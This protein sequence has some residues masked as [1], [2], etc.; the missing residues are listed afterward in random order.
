MADRADDPTQDAPSDPAP[1][2]TDAAVD[3]GNYGVLRRRL[4]D[5]ASAVK[6]A[7]DTLNA[8]RVDRFGSVSFEVLGQERVRTEHA[9]TPHDMVPIGDHLLVG[10]EV[11]L[12]LKQTTSPGDVFGLYTIDRSGDVPT[13]RPAA[14]SAR[15]F[16]EGPAFDRE[17]NELF[18]Y[19]ADARLT[20]LRRVDGR[21]LAVFRIGKRPE[22]VKV[23]RWDLTAD[24]TPTYVDNRGERDHVFP[25]AHD[26]TWTATTRDDHVRGRHPHVNVLDTVFVETVG[27]DLTVKVED[28]TETGEGVYSEPVDDPNQSLD[29][30]AIAYA[31]RGSLLLLRIT[32]FNE[33]VTR[34]LVFV[35]TTRQVLRI[36]ALGASCVTLPEDH[37][38]LFPGGYVLRDGQHKVFD[39]EHDGMRFVRRLDAPNGEDVLY[40]FHRASDGLY[41]LYSYNLIRKDVRTPIHAHGWSL[42][43]DGTL[44]VFRAQPDPTRVH[45]IQLWR[46]P[47]V[48]PEH[49]DPAAHGDDLIARVGNA[50]LV[51]GVSDALTLARLATHPEPTRA[52]FDELAAGCQR[53]LDAHYWASDASMHGL[54]EA[55]EA[56][57]QATEQVVDEFEKVLVLQRRA[58]DTLRAAREEHA[59]LMDAVRTERLTSIDA[60]LGAMT[61]LR[62]HRGHLITL[63]DVRFADR[64]AL[65]ALGDEAETR[66]E[67]VGQATIRFL[68]GE[69]AFAPLIQ[70]LA[71]VEA[72]L[73]G[74]RR[75][76][77]LEPWAERLTQTAEGVDLL[78]EVVAGLEVDDP[79][80][81]AALLDR[82][83]EVFSTANRVRLALEQREEALAAKEGEAE[84]SAQIKLLS[85]AVQ[86]ALARCDTPEA[87]DEQLS[88]LLLQVEELEARFGASDAFLPALTTQ[89]EDVHSAFAARRQRLLDDRNRR[90]AARVAAAD[91]IL[92]GLARRARTHT[93]EDALNS[94]FAADPMVGRLRALADEL[95]SL[96]DT[97][98][99]ED[100]RGRLRRTR[101]DALR[102][103]RDDAE[104]FDAD[105]LIS[106][107]RHKFTVNTQP[108][109]LALVPDGEGDDLHVALTLTGTQFR[110]RL[111]DPDVLAARAYWDQALVSETEAVYRAEYLA[112]RVLDAAQRGDGLDVSTLEQAL[113]TEAGL[114]D[115]VRSHTAEAWDEGY[116]RGVHDVDAAAIL[117]ALVQLRQAAGWQRFGTR[118][119]ALAMLFRG[120]HTDAPW[121]AWQAR[122]RTLVRIRD[123]LGPGGAAEAFATELTGVL[124]A[125]LQEIGFDVPGGPSQWAS[126]LPAAGAALVDALATEP[127]RMAVS[128]AAQDLRARLDRWIEDHGGRGAFDDRLRA[129]SDRPVEHLQV[130]HAWC[131]AIASTADAPADPG[132]AFETA[133]WWLVERQVDIQ[134]EA[135]EARTTVQ[136]LLGRHPRVRDGAMDL[137]LAP[138]LDRLTRF[139]TERVPGFRAWRATRHDVLE[140]WR[141][142]LRIDE[143]EPKVMSAF[144]RN[145][146]IQDAYLPLIGDN[147]A[148]QIGAAGDAKRTDLMGLLLLV[149]PP[150][151]GKTT[152]MEYVADRLGLVFVKVNGPALGHGVTSL[153]PEEAPNAT[154]RQEVDKINLALELGDNVLLYLDDI[155]HTNPELLQKFISLCDASRRI[156]GVWNGR[157][158]TYDL[159]GRK[160]AV[161]MAG[162]PYTESGDR[163]QVPDM[164]ANRAD[165]YNLGDVLDGREDVFA[166]SFV[167]NALTS[168]PVLQPLADRAQADVYA[169]VRM[170]QGEEL[171]P[172]ALSHDYSAVERS[173]ILTVLRHL[174]RCRDVLLRVN[175]EYVRSAAME[176]RF[177]TEPRFQLQGSYRNMAKLAQRIVPALRDEEVDRLIDDHYRGESQTLT[178]GAEFNL[179]RLAELRGR[180]DEVGAERLDAIRQETRRQRL[181]GG[182]GDDPA[183]RVVGVLSGL[184]EAVGTL[185][186]GLRDPAVPH[187]LAG[188]HEQLS[189]LRETMAS[190]RGTTQHLADLARALRAVHGQLAEAPPPDLQAVAGPL[191]AIAT[192]LATATPAPAPAVPG[193]MQDML[194]ELRSL[195]DAVR[196]SQGDPGALDHDARRARLLDQARRA[197]GGDLRRVPSDGDP[198]L[199][200]A[201]SVIEMLTVHML[202][203]ARAHLPKDAHEAWTQDLRRT[204]ASAIADLAARADRAREE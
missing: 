76:L 84:F 9:N 63:Q 100:L 165:T 157:T 52:A 115:I 36:D 26:F 33:A 114:L 123:T 90:V 112:W 147:F 155:Q 50:E 66:F 15:S 107:G 3:Q 127:A 93:D 151:Y 186:P 31:D 124:R 176:D 103:L 46:T 116:D 8:Q 68:E 77:E 138:F 75:T 146:L 73:P 59:S 14:E 128:S 173:E 188:L 160:F 196:P 74:V 185:G 16:L 37:G 118:A 192:H 200:A 1:E 49:V 24:D 126:D 102:A 22:D 29:D 197:V 96:G 60:L 183:T 144:V 69:A 169:L 179:L 125:W 4:A 17:F 195:R 193:A 187:A 89:R 161:V 61:R 119:R 38:I 99:A 162:N 177:R 153:D 105:R 40:V 111:D 178:T 104:L 72:A 42:F 170:A 65:Q 120:L 131:E 202:A 81:K 41:A 92:E 80:R 13:F 122:A 87:C 57:L 54:A 149:S 140:R 189:A 168:N 25:P 32:P 163:F 199:A 133:V 53:F 44:A 19:Y 70:G 201:L 39:A 152:L 11:F 58:A 182:D 78:A 158:R 139:A 167:E 43:D 134:V 190:D 21:L 171:P 35:R 67:R 172:S 23:L 48:H 181:M 130:L 28:N 95:V 191:Q 198:N 129:L 12:G 204:V 136:G 27:G 47:F 113:L 88:R 91:R 97:V 10:Y 203:S 34:H 86:S 132:V 79:T 55:V 56:T 30:A 98:R 154:A 83:G 184:V 106:L 85:Q 174:F 6:A 2:G 141:H 62:R 156:E 110:Q 166:L 7:A 20:Q 82:I 51:R 145:K 45:P 175:A 94:F 5:R 108:F 194:A 121:G 180:L 117:K 18:Q 71:E 148:K 137:S 150:G 64:A 143:L 135:T 159:R 142:R 101:Q 164:L 109:E